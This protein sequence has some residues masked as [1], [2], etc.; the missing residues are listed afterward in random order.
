MVFHLNLGF[1]SAYGRGWEAQCM[2]GPPTVYPRYG[3]IRGAWAP[4]SSRGTIEWLV[5]GFLEPVFATSVNIYETYNPGAVVEV[6][7]CSDDLDHWVTVW[8]EPVTVTTNNLT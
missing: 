4:L 1:S 5:F 2:V 8:K 3:D 7:T 6:Q